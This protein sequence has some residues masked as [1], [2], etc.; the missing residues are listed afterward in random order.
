M[1]VKLAR[2]ATASLVLVVLICVRPATGGLW[3]FSSE[4][5]GS[6]TKPRTN[7]VATSSQTQPSTLDKIGSGTKNFFTKVGNTVTGKKPK[8]DNSL[9]V[10]PK[11]PLAAKNKDK[12]WLPSWLGP[13]E[14]KPT[15]VKTYLKQTK[16]PELK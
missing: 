13:K 1:V 8:P 16:R 3:P 11:S 5:R 10:Y 14:N 12:S 9:P 6:D 2:I 15:D 7:I 4:N